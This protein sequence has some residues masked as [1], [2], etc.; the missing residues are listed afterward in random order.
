M[1]F[2]NKLKEYKTKHG[3]KALY[4]VFDSKFGIGKFEYVLNSN[5]FNP[6]LTI[7]LN[8]RSL[9]LKHAILFPIWV[10]GH[11]RIYS[12]SGNILIQSRIKSGMI[13][14]NINHPGG[15]SSSTTQSEIYNLGRIIFK[16]KGYIGSG[17]KIFVNYNA[18]LN[19]GDDFE[20]TDHTNIGC[21]QCIKI[22]SRFS[23]THKCQIFDSNYHYIADF[24]HR[25]IHTRSEDVI[26]GNGC[27]ICNSTTITPGSFLPDYT[28]VASNSL[29]NSKTNSIP[30]NSLIGGIPAKLL[31]TGYRRIYN[32]KYNA[33]LNSFFE[34]N[35]QEFTFPTEWTMEECTD[36]KILEK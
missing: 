15:P 32:K 13:K 24:K 36:Y 12:L 34:G 30:S 20:I 18:E 22:G 3:F 27:W 31:S 14:F 26:I 21:M 29:V 2:L 10:Y 4:I 8:F 16:G 17:N 19:I 6:L 23:L 5:W 11:P 25:T 9:P 7:W 1:N 35:N 33:Q 28:I